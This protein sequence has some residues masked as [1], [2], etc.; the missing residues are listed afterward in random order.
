[1]RDVA[2]ANFSSPLNLPL[3]RGGEGT[4]YAHLPMAVYALLGLS[5]WLGS[6][7]C[8][9]GALEYFCVELDWLFA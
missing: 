1:M 2:W 7:V 8:H 4:N 6:E 3:S 5:A 9:V